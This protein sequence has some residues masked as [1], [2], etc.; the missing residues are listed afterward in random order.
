MAL[1][2]ILGRQIAISAIFC[3]TKLNLFAVVVVVVVVV[4]G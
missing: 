2:A 3:V 4:G 1:I